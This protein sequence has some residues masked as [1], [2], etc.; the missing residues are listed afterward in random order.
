MAQFNPIPKSMQLCK[1]AFTTNGCDR[2]SSCAFSHNYDL[3][4][5]MSGQQQHATPVHQKK[6]KLT[7][8]QEMYRQIVEGSCDQFQGRSHQQQFAQGQIH[9]QRQQPQVQRQR[10]QTQVQTQQTPVQRQQPQVQCLRQQTPVQ[11]QQPPVQRQ[12]PPV[13]S[14][15]QQ[16]SVQR[17]QPPV[18]SQ[19]QQTPVRPV[20]TKPANI[21]LKKVTFE[22]TNAP[23]DP[24]DQ[25]I[26]DLSRRLALLEN[27][28]KKD[29]L[30]PCTKQ[31]N[32]EVL[33]PC[34][35]QILENF[36]QTLSAGAKALFQKK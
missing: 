26:A 14:Q 6:V 8:E 11:T 1:H 12:Q 20:A 7:P 30:K 21:V 3:Y 32:Q 35:T 15:T 23:I 29:V 19:T 33:K 27:Q 25:M 16:P 18:Q 5:A 9:V 22:A 4:L 13:Q 36:A 31:S 10:Q 2:G 28:S 24:K 34:K 17:Q